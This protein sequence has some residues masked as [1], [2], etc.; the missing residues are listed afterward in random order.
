MNLNCCKG[1]TEWSVDVLHLTQKVIETK[2]VVMA[3]ANK[4]KNASVDN[5]I[6][7]QH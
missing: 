3:V 4:S 6:I 1:N 2:D 5:N 7:L